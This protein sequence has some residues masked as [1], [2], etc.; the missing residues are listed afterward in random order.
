MHLGSKIK[1][2]YQAPARRGGRQ[3]KDQNELVFDELLYF[4]KPISYTGNNNYK[5]YLPTNMASGKTDRP[6]LQSTE[7]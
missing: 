7:P 3:S 6:K 2:A 1:W 4:A 5:A